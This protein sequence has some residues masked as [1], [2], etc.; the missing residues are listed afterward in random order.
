MGGEQDGL[1]KSRPEGICGELSLQP[2]ENWIPF[3]VMFDG[4]VPK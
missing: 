2:L 1:E 4:H 3:H